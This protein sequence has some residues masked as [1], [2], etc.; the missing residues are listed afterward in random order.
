MP[1]RCK[2]DSEGCYCQWGEQTKYYYPCDSKVGKENAERKAQKQGAAI[3]ISKG[4]FESY[5]DYPKSASEAACRAI[6]YKE[7]ND[8]DCGTRVGWTRARQ[9]CNRENISRDT[10]ARMASFKRHQ[11]NKDVP[12]DEGCGGLMWDAWGSDTGIEWAIRKLEQIDREENFSCSCGRSLEEHI[13]EIEYD[14][15]LTPKEKKEKIDDL[16]NY[17]DFIE[18]IERDF[19]FDSIGKEYD[20]QG[21]NV[22]H[23]YS[24]P[25]EEY[26]FRVINLYKYEPQ[27]GSAPIIDT[28]RRFCAQLYLRTSD[29]NSYLTF[30]E[31]QSLAN[32][33]A[34]YGVTDILRYC[35]NFT[36]DPNFTTCRH[37]WIRFKYDTETGNIVRDIRQPIY[38][39]TISD[40]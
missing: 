18:G 23:F 3:E 37:R 32:P 2:K 12:Y 16:T 22:L 35:G 27:P 6:K 8:S 11:Q 39:P 26:D 31:L 17:N 20:T 19:D 38:T 10:I 1:V 33:G 9:L 15:S 25:K 30:S 4:F 14:F 13:K 21:S 24:I 34:R 28:S 29:R 7:E 36:T 40:R 5:N